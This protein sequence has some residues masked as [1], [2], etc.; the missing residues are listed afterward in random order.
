MQAHDTNSGSDR[1][2]A[3]WEGRPLTEIPMSHGTTVL[4]DPE[5]EDAWVQMDTA[6]TAVFDPDE[7]EH[8]VRYDRHSGVYR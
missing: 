3:E 4:Q 5:N 1:Q 8:V 6:S 2:Q 7:E